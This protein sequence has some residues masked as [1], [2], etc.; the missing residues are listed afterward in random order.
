MFSKRRSNQNVLLFLAFIYKTTSQ[1]I[2]L[3]SNEPIKQK[4]R[5]RGQNFMKD[6]L[7]RNSLA[8]SIFKFQTSDSIQIDSLL[9]SHSFQSFTEPS[10]GPDHSQP[11]TMYVSPSRTQKP[12]SFT[13]S[14]TTHRCL[15][16]SQGNKEEPSN[17]CKF[18]KRPGNKL[19][20]E[21]R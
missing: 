14:A 1:S 4:W 20:F 13:A 5:E 17:N 11:S 8:R 9:F 19:L 2:E 6:F 16:F 15:D 3:A 18:F 10:S 7:F 21:K 12:L